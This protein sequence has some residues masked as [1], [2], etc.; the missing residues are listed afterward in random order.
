MGS[1]IYVERIG[2][3]RQR[4]GCRVSD[5]QDDIVWTIAIDRGWACGR[6]GDGRDPVVNPLGEVQHREALS[7]ASMVCAGSFRI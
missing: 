4:K 5:L 1:H 6:E 2:N 3:P 7:G